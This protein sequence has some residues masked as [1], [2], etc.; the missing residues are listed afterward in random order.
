MH[1][2]EG[3]TTNQAIHGSLKHS[4]FTSEV[5]ALLGK[6]L[7]LTNPHSKAATISRDDGLGRLISCLDASS[8]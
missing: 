1:I 5:G 8:C 2:V 6:I 4:G 3:D 7:S